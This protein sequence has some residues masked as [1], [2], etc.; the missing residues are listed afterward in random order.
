METFLEQF[1]SPSVFVNKK[2]LSPPPSIA[3]FKT[4]FHEFQCWSK[5]KET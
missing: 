2:Y 4:V 1:Y 3:H 5:T